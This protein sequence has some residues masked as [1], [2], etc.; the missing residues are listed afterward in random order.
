MPIDSCVYVRYTGNRPT[1]AT[2]G[3]AGHDLTYNLPETIQINPG[4]WKLISTGLSLEIPTGHA[5]L[6]MPRSGLALRNGITVLNSP[7]L[8]DSDYRGDIGVILHN[9]SKTPFVVLPGMRIAQLVVIAVP[10]L[11]LVAGGNLSD[12]VRGVGGFGST[13]H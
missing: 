8:I 4:D 3:S 2:A 9:I 6:V 10:D 7:G 11:V 1:A 13:G 5:G 12:T